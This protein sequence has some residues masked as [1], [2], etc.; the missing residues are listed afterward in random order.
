[1]KRVVFSE[2]YKIEIEEAPRPVK[3]PGEA[4]LKVR[5]V[6]ICGSD[7]HTYRGSSALVNTPVIPGHELCC[8]VLESEG[9][10]SKGDTVVVE[11]LLSCGKCYPCSI[12]RY[13]CCENLRVLGIQTEGGMVEEISLPIKLLHRIP[14]TADASLAPLVE[15]LSIGFHACNRG[16]VGPSDDVLILGS[17]P[18]G[19]GAALIA[20]EKGARVGI[21][22]P[23]TSRLLLAS[24][25]GIDYTFQESCDIESQVIG[26]FGRRPTVVIEAVGNVRTL[27]Q[28]LEIVSAAGRVVLVGW[29]AEP[30]KWR[31]DFFLRRELDLIG[32]RNSCGIFPKVIDFFCKNLDKIRHFVTHRFKMQEIETAMHLIDTSGAQTMKV[33][34]EW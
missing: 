30:P 22:D 2:P 9:K 28:G 10:L 3:K 29:I 21:V 6:G 25:L 11:P 18:I 12:G 14:T 4:I 17:G 8:E 13:N 7:L 26:K 16:R 20:K 32:A 15:T 24:E 27:E 19:L 5:Y 23:L 1:M 33:I 34:M 31:P